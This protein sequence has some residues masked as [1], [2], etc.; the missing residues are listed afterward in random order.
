MPELM[1]LREI[2]PSATIVPGARIGPFCTIGPHVTIGAGTLCHR[3]VC[4]AGHTTI[5]A[6]NDI[7]E[8]C[9]LGALP[10]DLKYHGE[11]SLLLV[12]DRNRLGR[13]VTI[14]VGTEAGGWLT[15][16]GN[17]NVLNDEAHVAHDCYVDDHTFLGRGVLLAGHVRVNVRIGPF[18]T[19]GPHVTIGAVM[20]DQSAAHHFTTIGRY[21]R[22][23]ARTP[24]R[25][26][27]PPY[28]DFY[29]DNSATS[30]P[31][32][33]GI[34]K[35]GILRARLPKDEEVELRFALRELFADET[36]LQTKIEQLR[37]LG[38][39]GEAAAL[40]TFCQRSLQGPYGRHRE[41]FR[42]QTP[43]EA[44]PPTVGRVSS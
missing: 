7:A 43:P 41:V 5:G 31:G 21:A 26:D 16:V 6:D 17:D 4:I 42:G 13:N 20:E 11:A 2:A 33:R 35:D 10:Q 19:I 28:T 25:R 40:C 27:V 15:R 44:V 29:S 30:A 8:G 24:V 36:A 18:C 37:N 23:R 9:V 14:H 1:V 38:V 12:G 39:E 34:H 32:V 3:R 22:V